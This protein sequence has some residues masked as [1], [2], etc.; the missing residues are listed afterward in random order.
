[1]PV[2]AITHSLMPMPPIIHRYARYS[3]TQLRELDSQ[4]RRACFPD[5]GDELPAPEEVERWF[6]EGLASQGGRDAMPLPLHA[7]HMQLLRF[8]RLGLVR[9]GEAKILYCSDLDGTAFP[10]AGKYGEHAWTPQK[11]ADHERSLMRFIEYAIPGVNTPMLYFGMLFSMFCWHVEDQY[12]YSTSYLHEGAAKTWYG[13]SSAH[14]MAF[15]AAFSSAFPSSVESD[16]ELF[17]KKASMVMPRY[18]QRERARVLP[19]T[20]H[21]L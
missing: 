5:D 18:I 11:L 17:V 9:L 2:P 19:C 20:R 3:L 16:P 12:M 7:W 1:M 21:A 8:L 14:A 15:E 10:R 6:W 4:L 13:V